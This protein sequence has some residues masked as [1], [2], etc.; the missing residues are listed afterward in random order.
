MKNWNDLTDEQV[1]KV[2]ITIYLVVIAACVW[3]GV[4]RLVFG[5]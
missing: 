3:Y 1:G 4:Y 2:V 5:W